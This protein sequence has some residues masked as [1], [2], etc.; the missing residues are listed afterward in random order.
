MQAYAGQPQQGS[1]RG[2]NYRSKSIASGPTESAK[3]LEA[4]RQKEQEIQDLKQ[5][6]NRFQ[7]QSPNESV[8]IAQDSSQARPFRKYNFLQSPN[9]SAAHAR[10]MTPNNARPYQSKSGSTFVDQLYRDI[11]FNLNKK[12]LRANFQPGAF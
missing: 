6:M 3:L 12:V 8:S 5:Q 11:E 1:N 10:A 9:A 2:D 4:L 7:A